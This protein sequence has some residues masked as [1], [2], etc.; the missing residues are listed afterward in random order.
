MR[1]K[2]HYVIDTSGQYKVLKNYN[3]L[4]TVPKYQKFTKIFLQ[5]SYA[6][7]LESVNSFSF[8]WTEMFTVLCLN[9]YV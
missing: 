4:S 5:T 6:D 3:I 1:M 7:M 9:I 8:F 2:F